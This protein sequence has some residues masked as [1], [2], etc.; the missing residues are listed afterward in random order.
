MESLT[1]C[2]QKYF[3]CV[4]VVLVS[5]KNIFYLPILCCYVEFFILASSN[6]NTCLLYYLLSETRQ[7][8]GFRFK[9]NYSI[10]V[11][12]CQIWLTNCHSSSLG[13]ERHLCINSHHCCCCSD[14]Q[15]CPTLQPH[16]LQ[17]AQLP[18]LS[19]SPSAY[20]NS[21]PLNQWS[22]PT[23]LSSVIA[24]SSCPQSFPASGYLLVS[25]L[26]A[27][28]GQSKGARFWGFEHG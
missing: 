2:I 5:W 17:P 20:T 15:S 10:F 14:S 22:H 12:Q 23:I 9:R 16:G 11:L 7:I 13:K 24:F 8:L 19:P 1:K 28:G 25:W 26:F 4:V 21:C 18:C 3:F 27:L 6:T